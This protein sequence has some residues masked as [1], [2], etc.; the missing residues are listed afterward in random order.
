[1]SVT[2]ASIV[3]G[4]KIWNRKSHPATDWYDKKDVSRAAEKHT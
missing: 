4:T 3:E 1:M 2:G